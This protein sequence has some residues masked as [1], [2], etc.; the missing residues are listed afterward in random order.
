MNEQT[1]EQMCTITHHPLHTQHTQRTHHTVKILHRSD[2]SEMI[3]A[4][5]LFGILYE[6][7]IFDVCI[8]K[9]LLSFTAVCEE[10]R[11]SAQASLIT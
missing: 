1:N 4:K 8:G 7:N 3:Q 10:R 5:V 9:V 11:C 2:I 6:V